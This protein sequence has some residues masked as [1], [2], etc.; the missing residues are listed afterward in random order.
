MTQTSTAMRWG[1][2]FTALSAGLHLLAL[3]VSRF[4]ADA[5]ILLPFA[6]VYAGFAYGLFRGWRWLAYVVFIVLLV[7]ISL[8]IAR[9]WANGDV[10]R[11]IYMG[12]AGANILSVTTLFVALWKQPDVIT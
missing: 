8:A 7:G 4:S 3:P 6:L 1:A 9:I 10:P 5:L 2:Y 12:I 11:W